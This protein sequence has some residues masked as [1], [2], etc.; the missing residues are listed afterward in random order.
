MP[1]VPSLFDFSSFPVLP[2]FQLF[3]PSIVLA[4]TPLQLSGRS[5]FS[6]LPAFSNRSS[7]AFMPFQLSGRLSHFGFLVVLFIRIIPAQSNQALLLVV[8]IICNTFFY[9]FNAY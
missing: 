3:Q 7:T 5:S 4:F 8:P 1:V 6:E 9:L 2:A